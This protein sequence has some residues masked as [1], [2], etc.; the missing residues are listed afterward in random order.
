MNGRLKHSLFALAVLTGLAGAQ[1]AS[2]GSCGYTYCW[3][4]VMIGPNGA[5]G[6]SHSWSTEQQAYDAAM[7]GCKYD[8]TE[9][10]TFANACAALAQ[11]SNGYWGWGQAQSRPEAEATALSYCAQGAYDCQVRV[12]ACSQ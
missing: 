1:A 11:G 5:W 8:C 10:R 2:A 12:W 4:A 3:G 7:E 6:Y 9:Y